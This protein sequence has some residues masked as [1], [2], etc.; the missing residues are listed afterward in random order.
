MF[1]QEQQG[2]HSAEL[3]QL[4]L[5]QKQFSSGV[6]VVAHPIGATTM[7]MS[8]GVATMS[9]LVYRRVVSGNVSKNIHMPINAA[10]M[11]VRIIG[12]GA[13]PTNDI[14]TCDLQLKSGE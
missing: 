10:W 1:T 7:S 11:R 6:F 9:D 13:H 14:I 3:T 8:S 4:A 2:P 12:T 5:W